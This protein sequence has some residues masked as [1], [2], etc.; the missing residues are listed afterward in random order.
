MSLDLR[1]PMGLMFSLTGLIMTL[2]GLST[3][4]NTELY[5]KSLGIN[6]NLWWGLVLLIFG[7]VN[8]FLGRRGQKRMES[9]PLVSDEEGEVRRGH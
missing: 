8:V 7:L 5:A 2:F 3:N 6:A 1:L 9:E 4:G